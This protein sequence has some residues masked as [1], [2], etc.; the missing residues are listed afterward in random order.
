MAL[1]IGTHTLDTAVGP[2]PRQS[3]RRMWP[4]ALP[5]GQGRLK[6]APGTQ[7][8]AEF[9]PL[10][11]D[12]LAS[13]AVV[14]ASRSNQGGGVRVTLAL[15]LRLHRV[16]V[17]GGVGT[18]TVHR[19]D[20]DAIAEQATTQAT[21]G[22]TIQLSQAFTDRQFVLKQNG[23]SLTTDQIAQLWFISYPTTPRLGVLDEQGS[24]VP[25]WQA[26]GQLTASSAQG[27][28]T[29]TT[30]DFQPLERRL[31]GPSPPTL[32]LV[33]ESDAPCQIQITSASLSYRRV[34][35]GFTPLGG[36]AKQVLRF[37]G[38]DL[39]PQSVALS[40]PPQVQTASIQL[41]VSLR[42]AQPATASLATATQAPPTQ[43]QGVEL[44]PQ[45]WGA[46]PFTPTAATRYSGITLG[47]LLLRSQT[48]LTVDL[49]TDEGGL[50]G[51]S[52][53]RTSQTVQGAGQPQWV[54]LQL[55]AAAVVYS[56]PYWLLVGVSEP[57]LWL[58]HPGDG[59]IYLLEHS[60]QAL[61]STRHHYSKTQ[62]LHHWIE[63]EAA[64]SAQ[65]NHGTGAGGHPALSLR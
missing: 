16:T 49:R 11:F 53:S 45:Q 33:A 65:A 29:L 6:V 36:T 40:L 48:T 32:K 13:G 20:G 26:P 7:I 2:P 34:Y 4:L 47:L 63:L 37:Q 21:S 10:T 19:V 1:P 22:G 38:H 43:R 17:T 28:L 64:L 54:T 23:G 9:L 18:I 3:F 5:A 12:A 35:Q 55:P 39:R 8:Q 14:T 56:Q 50:P 44:W 31:T 15:P 62:A 24:L 27:Q 51:L 52:L 41:S 60:P 57:T 25:L 59:E 42:G 46:L 61:W 30:A 58:T